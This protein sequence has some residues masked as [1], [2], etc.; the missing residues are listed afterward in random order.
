M[1]SFS[2]PGDE[3]RIIPEQCQQPILPSLDNHLSLTTYD[4]SAQS[5]STSYPAS[6]VTEI[7]ESETSRQTLLGMVL[8]AIGTALFCTVGALV[9]YHGGSVL[10]LMFGRYIVQNVV[11]WILWCCNPCRLRGDAVHWFGDAPHRKNIWCRGLLLFLTVLFWWRG[12]E[13]VPLGP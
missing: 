9:Q 7:D 12:L 2:D 8:V 3:D 11:S 13:L 4:R 6:I 10:Q 5:E 1:A